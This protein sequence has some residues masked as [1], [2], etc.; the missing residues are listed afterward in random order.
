MI[1]AAASVV[2][3]AAPSAVVTAALSVAVAAAVVSVVETAALV[4]HSQNSQ[5]LPPPALPRPVSSP[6]GFGTHTLGSLPLPHPRQTQTHPLHPSR[7][8][9]LYHRDRVWCSGP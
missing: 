7:S 2:A 8:R 3:A 9:H 6:S 4:T 1:V 5:V